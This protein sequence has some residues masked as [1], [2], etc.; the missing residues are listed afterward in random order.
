MTDMLAT[1][2]DLKQILN[3]DD[4]EKRLAMYVMKLE[5]EFNDAEREFVESMSKKV[6]VNFLN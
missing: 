2:D 5:N 1:I 3:S 4:V 6:F